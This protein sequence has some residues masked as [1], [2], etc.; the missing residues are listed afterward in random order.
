MTGPADHGTRW[1]FVR[2]R[3][4]DEIPEEIVSG[5]VANL[6]HKPATEEAVINDAI[7][8][9]SM[10]RCPLDKPLDHVLRDLLEKQ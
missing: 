4:S 1:F 2:Y 3:E 6:A 8:K 10:L 7:K 9:L 5:F